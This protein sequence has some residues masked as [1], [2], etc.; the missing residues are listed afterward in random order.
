MKKVLFAIFLAASVIIAVSIIFSNGSGEQEANVEPVVSLS[1]ED[2]AGIKTFS[3][4]EERGENFSVL[5]TSEVVRRLETS[6]DM[7]ERR[8]AAK[9]LGDRSIAGSLKMSAQEKEAVAKVVEG[10]L[11]Q[12]KASTAEQRVEARQQVER[13][14]HVAAPTLLEHVNSKDGDGGQV[15]YS[16]AK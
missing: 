7:I 15:A 2:D 1:L 4:P 5:E 16:H 8:K 11:R 9:V 12:A 13:L 10:Y 3:R 6:Q 14:W